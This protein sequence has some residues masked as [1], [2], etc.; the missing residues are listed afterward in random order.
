MQQYPS[1]S[2]APVETAEARRREILLGLLATLIFAVILFFTAAPQLG[3]TGLYADQILHEL[4]SPV[5]AGN[6]IW[7]SG[8]LLWRPLGWALVHLFSPVLSSL[9]GWTVR[10]QIIFLLT[11][12]S[13]V[14]A[15]CSVFLWY[16]IGVRATGSA[17][18]AFALALGLGCTHGCLLYAQTGCSYIA[19]LAALSASIFALSRDKVTAGALYFGLAGIFWLPYLFAGIGLFVLAG[20][21]GTWFTPFSSGLRNFQIRRALRFCVLSGAVVLITLCGALAARRI[22]TPAAFSDWFFAATHGWAQTARLLRTATGLP[23]SFFDLGHDGLLFKRYLLHDPYAP[24]SLS[25]LLLASLWKIALF[26]LFL[27]SIIVELI[28]YRREGWTRF[29][30]AAEF[31]PIMGFAIFVF[32]PSSPERYLP[33]LPFLSLI[34]GRILLDMPKQR[35]ITQGIITLTFVSLAI[36]N[37]WSLSAGKSREL[38]AAQRARIIELRPKMKTTDLL[39]ALPKDELLFFASRATYDDINRP[40]PITML[41]AVVPATASVPLWRETLRKQIVE[42]WQKGGDVWISTRFWS[43][44]PKPE[45]GWAEGDDKR[46]TWKQITEFFAP[47]KTDL[48]SGGMDGFRRLIPGQLPQ[49]Q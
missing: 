21:P 10:M 5:G 13:V 33:M 25:D 17:K 34:C 47:F 3:D 12:V 46:V 41:E 31:L 49:L 20:I 8:H 24:T 38:D 30:F 14:G 23:R 6:A 48:S 45:W 22:S 44:T 19:G 27:L 9:T 1:P 42:T 7:E 29:L 11:A 36:S 40:V 26:H 43:A 2:D 15:L 4:N 28:F 16:R 37:C 35:R 32:E 18:L 39:V